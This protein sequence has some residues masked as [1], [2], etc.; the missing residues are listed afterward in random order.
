M[1]EIV[2]NRAATIVN[3][4]REHG[5]A[6][7]VVRVLTSPARRGLVRLEVQDPDN[8]PLDGPVVIVA[9]HLSFIDSVL[10]M[11]SLPRPVSVLGKAEYTDRRITDDDIYYNSGRA[12]VGGRSGELQ[13]TSRFE[14]ED[15]VGPFGHAAYCGIRHGQKHTFRLIA[16]G[17]YFQFY[18]DDYYVQTFLVPEKFTGRIGLVVCDGACQFA[19]LKAWDTNI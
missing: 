18:I 1:L 8:L 5:A 3:D 15:T 12:L 7:E 9:N 2:R 10:M 11:F 17:E 19:G 13:G 4:C 16:R 6:Y 14:C